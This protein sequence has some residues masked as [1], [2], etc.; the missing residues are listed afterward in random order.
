MQSAVFGSR[1]APR[2]GLRP[3]RIE[4]VPRFLELLQK[5]QGVAETEAGLLTLRDCQGRHGQEVPERP[6]RS[7]ILFTLKGGPG[8]VQGVCQIHSVSSHRFASPGCLNL[9]TRRCG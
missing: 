7:D 8:Q 9:S 2:P 3:K 5:S 1:I 4:E 6:F